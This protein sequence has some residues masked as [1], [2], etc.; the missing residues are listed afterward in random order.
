MAKYEVIQPAVIVDAIQFRK[1]KK[2]PESEYYQIHKIDDKYIFFSTVFQ[3]ELNDKEWIIRQKDGHLYIL[4]DSL[5]KTRFRKV[6]DVKEKKN[7]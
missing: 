7:A 5:F 6:I 1:N 4:T 2:L 3:R